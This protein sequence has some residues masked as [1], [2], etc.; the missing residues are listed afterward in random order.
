MFP[1]PKQQQCQQAEHSSL[2]IPI[3]E[4]VRAMVLR[5][6]ALRLLAVMCNMTHCG[7]IQETHY[8][9]TPPQLFSIQNQFV[10]GKK[11]LSP[12]PSG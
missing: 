3:T 6:C 11:Y 9:P 12:R 7:F 1:V 8:S 10:L 4:I 5:N 2:L